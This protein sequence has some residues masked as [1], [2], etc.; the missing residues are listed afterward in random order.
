MAEKL[1][2][3]RGEKIDVSYS[4]KRC[5]HAEACVHGLPAVFDRNRRPWVLPDNG[6]VERVIEVVESCPTGA[7]HYEAKDGHPP[8]AP[9]D[10]NVITLGIDGPLYVRGDI[11][12]VSP[13]GGSLILRD[14]RMA[15]CRCGASQNKPFCDDNHH[16]TGFTATDGIQIESKSNKD[17][18]Q[19]KTLK[20]TPRVNGSLLFEGNFEIRASNG[21]PL[22]TGRRATF[23][24]CG[25][26]KNKP[27]CD[28]THRENGFTTEPLSAE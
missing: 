18:P 25:G 23:C 4:L 27:F 19:G 11:E 14:T 21:S 13:D 12:I 6:D 28:G 3:Y 1:H 24:R 2:R 17:S 9:P 26:S 10:T 5:I 7:L 15:L 22:D 20:I 16:S 8:E